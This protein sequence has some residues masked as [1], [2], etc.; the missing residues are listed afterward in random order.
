MTE[1]SLCLPLFAGAFPVTVAELDMLQHMLGSSS[2]LVTGTSRDYRNY[3][4]YGRSDQTAL[5][6]LAR[7]IVR[8]RES[9]LLHADDWCL[10]VNPDALNGHLRSAK[11]DTMRRWVVVVDDGYERYPPS[12]FLAP[13]R[14]K[15]R[16][17]AALNLHDA[18]NCGI[19]KALCFVK[20]VRLDE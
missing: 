8:A 10:H 18:W 19:K 16:Y 1:T 20:S 13:T 11:L 2:G 7:G 4:C 12:T 14:S 15:A 3:G 6:L 5:A 17:Q 9:S